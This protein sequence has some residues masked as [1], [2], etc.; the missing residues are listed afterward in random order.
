[1]RVH[2]VG[3][4]PD[5]ELF[6]GHVGEPGALRQHFQLGRIPERE[7]AAGAD[8]GTAAHEAVRHGGHADAGHP[9]VVLDAA[10]RE[11]AEPA[12]R[13]EYAKDL[14]ERDSGIRREHQPHAAGHDVERSI[15]PVDGRRVDDRGLD[16]AERRVPATGDLDH[17]RGDVAHDDRAGRADELRPRG[18]EA[19]RTGRQ[20]EHP[21]AGLHGHAIEECCGGFDRVVVDV[22]RVRVPRFRH[23]APCL[24]GVRA[25]SAVRT[26]RAVRHAVLLYGYS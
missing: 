18:A 22:L 2:G 26:V 21:I 16:V 12:I 11:R 10:P 25:G 6:D 24:G 15:G 23:C 1:M 14:G 7:D 5:G 13:T 4:E 20:L 8:R 17:P 19:T 3:P 9:G